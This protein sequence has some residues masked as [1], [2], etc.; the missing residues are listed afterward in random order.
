M[1]IA[2]II[3]G[4]SPAYIPN[5]INT[6]L[7]SN[8]GEI[9][10]AIYT[11]V[12]GFDSQFAMAV[13][14]NTGIMLNGSISNSNSSI[15]YNDNS[16]RQF[17][18]L[19]IG[20]YRKINEKARIETFG[21]FGIGKV[22]GQF[23]IAHNGDY[24]EAHFNRIFFQ[25]TFGLT[26]KIFDGSIAPRFVAVSIYHPSISGLGI[27][28]EPVVTCKIGYKNVKAVFQIG[29]SLPLNYKQI[30]FD[31]QP[32]IFS[33]GIQGIFNRKD[34]ISKKNTSEID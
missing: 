34:W 19:G 14:D 18:E 25:P 13:S 22:H 6:P 26:S 24:S 1:V 7:L 28:L 9:Q 11:G 31:Y 2:I 4:C 20:H 27:F 17:V 32:M 23:N 21:G 5:V 30:H 12:S 29:I 15:E 8:K 33:V 3:N 16:R 10:A